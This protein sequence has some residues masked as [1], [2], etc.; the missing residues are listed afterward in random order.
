MGRKS[1]APIPLK[2]FMRALPDYPDRHGCGH[3]MHCLRRLL[4]DFRLLKPTAM[5]AS[6]VDFPRCMCYSFRYEQSGLFSRSCAQEV[7]STVVGFSLAG[8]RSS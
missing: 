1:F 5:V 6:R 4:R 3:I 8:T 7:E 2:R